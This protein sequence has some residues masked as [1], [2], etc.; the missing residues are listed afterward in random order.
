MLT[1]NEHA[2]ADAYFVIKCI[3]IRSVCMLHAESCHF[4]SSTLLVL[5]D[6]VYDHQE[7]QCSSRFSL[8]DAVAGLCAICQCIETAK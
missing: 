1:R 8:L 6:F 3:D 7:P 5:I 4:C 2:V